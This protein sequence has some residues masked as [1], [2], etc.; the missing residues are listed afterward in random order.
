MRIALGLALTL[1][2]CHG[3]TGGMG[4]YGFGGP[5]V[6]I[7]V[8]GQHLGP[9]AP[10]PGAG[11]SLVDTRD[12]ASGAV[13]DSRFAAT[14]A[15]SSAG[16][17]CQLSFDRFGD[18]IPPIGVGYYQLSAEGATATADGT[19]APVGGERLIGP[20]DSWSCSGS[21]CD[22]ALLGITAIDAAHVEGYFSGTLA[23]D[24]GGPTAD[25]VCSFYLAM[26]TFSP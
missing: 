13:T 3:A 23:S 7:T 21:A 24:R 17:T 10:D 12:P 22:G 2:S 11:A 6:E 15:S 9:A 20:A 14:V 25:V 8:D 5:T 18:G 19:V 16:A 26:T 1:C 4:A